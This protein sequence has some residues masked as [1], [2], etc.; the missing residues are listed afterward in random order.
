MFGFGIVV[1]FG[2]VGIILTIVNNLLKKKGKQF[3]LVDYKKWKNEK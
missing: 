2:I 3:G 1:G